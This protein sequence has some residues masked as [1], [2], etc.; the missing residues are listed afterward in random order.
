MKSKFTILLS[1]L[2]FIPL[3]VQANTSTG[4]YDLINNLNKTLK[5]QLHLKNKPGIKHISTFQ[6]NSQIIIKVNYNP[7]ICYSNLI[8]SIAKTASRINGVNFQNSF[9]LEI[10]DSYCKDDLFYTIQSKGLNKDVMVQYEDLKGNGVAQ[11]RINKTLCQTN[12]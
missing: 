2:F 12:N 10:I 9:T 3:C 6:K 5:S 8:Q 7:K 4:E 11:H 1:S